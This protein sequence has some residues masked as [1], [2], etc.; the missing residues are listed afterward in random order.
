MIMPTKHIP[1]EQSLLGTGAV[2]FA[3]FFPSAHCDVSSSSPELGVSD[4]QLRPPSHTPGGAGA[5][6]SS[7]AFAA[8]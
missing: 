7:S 4:P 5:R 1:A 2:A 6:F 8:D 3:E